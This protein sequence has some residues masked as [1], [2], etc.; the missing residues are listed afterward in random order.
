MPKKSY[1]K[2]NVP[3]EIKTAFALK[4]KELGHSEASLLLFLV[5]TLL[6][7]N[8]VDVE[9]PAPTETKDESV[10]VWLNGR[11]KGELRK[12]AG[13]QGMKRLSPYVEVMLRTHLSQKP[14]FTERELEVLRQSN[15]ELTAIGRNVNQIAKA[16][17]S[18]LD[19]VHLLKAADVVQV[20]EQVKRVR[21]EVRALIR[22]NLSAWGV[23][24][25][26][27]TY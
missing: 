1:V 12:R 19:N 20:G 15:H 18:S 9:V 16:L 25:G 3:Q 13:E 17:N 8:P 14:Y 6:K 2:T 26:T 4:A 21:E 5:E 23:E 22:A 10:R 27:E 11:M 24:H 7:A